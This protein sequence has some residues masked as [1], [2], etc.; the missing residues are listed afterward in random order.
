MGQVI[1]YSK[2]LEPIEMNIK[3]N[4]FLIWCKRKK[5]HKP[6]KLLILILDFITPLKKNYFRKMLTFHQKYHFLMFQTKIFK[7]MG[8]MNK[9]TDFMKW[10]IERRIILERNKQKVDKDKAMVRGLIYSLQQLMY[11]HQK[12]HQTITKKKYIY[13]FLKFH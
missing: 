4:L 1:K 10:F 5:G 8:H 12:M 13:L 7:K 9:A 3:K 6:Q 11:Q 2:I